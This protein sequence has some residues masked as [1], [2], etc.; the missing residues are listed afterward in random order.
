MG[1]GL[2]MKSPG[3]R[4]LL[5]DRVAPGGV[6]IELGVAEGRYAEQVLRR[7]PQLKYL[8]VDAWAD[9]HDEAE[10]GRAL[11]RLQ[12]WR[13]RVLLWRMR[14]DEAVHEVGNVSADVVYVDGYAHTGQEGGQTLRDWWPKV[15]PGGVL[16]GH[17][18]ARRWPR[19]CRAVDEFARA[20][21]LPVQV[22]QDKPF[23]SWAITKPKEPLGPMLDPEARVIVVGNGPSLLKDDWGTDI[24]SF[25]EVVRINRYRLGGFERYTGSRTTLWATVGHGEVPGDTTHRRAPKVLMVQ[26]KQKP[27]YFPERLWRIPRSFFSDVTRR[28]RAVSVLPRAAEIIPSSGLVVLLW[29]LEGEGLP[30]V[31]AVGFDHFR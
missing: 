20:L 15:A 29:L 2:D 25:D 4:V 8:G 21:G 6:F 28:V 11:T 17:D 26:E 23:A 7:N 30:T 1:S 14:F 10:R 31:W 16:A 18:Y 13:D 19:T 3:G 5:A 27:G 12:A 9:H 22:I 24:D